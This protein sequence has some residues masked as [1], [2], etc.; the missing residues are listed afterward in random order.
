VAIETNTSRRSPARAGVPSA[1]R[2][3]ATAAIETNTSRRSPARAGVPSATRSEATAAIATTVLDRLGTMVFERIGIQIPSEELARLILEAFDQVV[4]VRRPVD[5]A[6]E[7]PA[8]EA[9]ALARAGIL[10]EPVDYYGADDP[11]VRTAAKYAAIVASSLTVAQAAAK[12]G[13]DPSRVRHRL[14]ARKLYG[15]RLPSGWRLPA[16]QFEGDKL[17]PNIDRVLPRLDPGLH[18]LGV[19]NWFTLPNVDLFFDE[20]ETPVSPLEWLRGGGDPRT[21]AE[22]AKDIGGIA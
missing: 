18:P 8:E 1:T 7:V 12:L 11:V 5:P 19:I 20:D 9:A 3:E 10:L 2:S 16:F 6:R 4:A 13:I 21:L 15:I 17:V 22:L 14:A